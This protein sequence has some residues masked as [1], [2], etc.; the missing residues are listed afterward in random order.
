V[1]HAVEKEG[2]L[3]FPAFFEGFFQG[4]IFEF[5]YHAANGLQRILG[6]VRFN[7]P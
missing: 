5:V 2:Q 7:A 1:D 4:F 3:V 6:K